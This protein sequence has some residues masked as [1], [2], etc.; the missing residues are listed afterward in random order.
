MKRIVVTIVAVVVL[1]GAGYGGYAAYGMGYSGG[2]KAGYDGGHSAEVMSLRGAL[3][4]SNLKRGTRLPRPSVEGLA[5]TRN[6][7]SQ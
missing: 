6:F 5:M 1:A 4:R 7:G 2:E 3:R